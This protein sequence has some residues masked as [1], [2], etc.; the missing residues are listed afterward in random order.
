MLIFANAG[1]PMLYV[2]LPW[3]I[4]LLI[5]IV[6]LEACWY[7]RFLRIPWR[8]A[9]GGSCG[10]N[11]WSTCIGLPVAWFVWVVVGHAS[12]ATAQSSGVVTQQMMLESYPIGFLYLVATS[13]WLIPTPGMGEVLLLG[14][15]M[16]LLLPAYLVSYMG[17]ARILQSQWSAREP[18]EVYRQ[19]W[20]AHL[21][22]YGLLYLLAG[23]RFYRA[24]QG[25]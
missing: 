23:Y 2:G 8:A 11:L 24:T 7:W 13:G 15:G 17:E 10:A 19:V 6:L 5:P 22:S 25:E 4:G 12:L 20:R 14:A 1:V 9:W 16:V 21:L 18:K 3:M